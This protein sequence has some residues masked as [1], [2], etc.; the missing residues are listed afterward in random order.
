VNIS[1]PTQNIIAV[2]T[3]LRARE[4]VF[5]RIDGSPAV[6]GSALWE[7]IWE[8]SGEELAYSLML[9]KLETERD[10]AKYMAVFGRL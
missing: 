8:M 4:Y 10:R 1:E 5:T 3:L 9:V 6:L 2:S 7:L